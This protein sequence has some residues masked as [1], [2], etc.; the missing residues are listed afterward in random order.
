L[1]FVSKFNGINSLHSR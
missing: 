1:A